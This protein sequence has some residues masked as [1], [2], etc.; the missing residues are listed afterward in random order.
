MSVVCDTSAGANDSKMSL[1]NRIESNRSHPIRIRIESR[2]FAGVYL[3]VF[4][5][6]RLP[7]RSVDR[8]IYT[9]AFMVVFQS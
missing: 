1:S 3:I 2:S 6:G 4:D 9:Y 8:L 5:L 7:V